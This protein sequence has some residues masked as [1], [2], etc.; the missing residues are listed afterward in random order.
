MLLILLM[1]K[2]SKEALT[3]LIVTHVTHVERVESGVCGLY[4]QY[5]YIQCY[6]ERVEI[7]CYVKTRVKHI[8]AHNFLNIQPIFNL[9]KVLETWDLDLLNHTIQCYVCWRGQKLFRLS[10]PS[11]CFNIHSIGWYAWKGLSLRFPKLF[12]DWKSVEFKKVMSKNVYVPCFNI[13]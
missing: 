4:T 13:T 12:A 6:V 8:F 5:R 9:Q 1:L 2:G 11:T 7:L 10:T 3:V